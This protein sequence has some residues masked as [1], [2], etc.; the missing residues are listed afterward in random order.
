[1]LRERYRNLLEKTE[2][3]E[4]GKIYEIRVNAGATETLK[5]IKLEFLFLVVT[6]LDSKEIPI[7]IEILCLKKFLLIK[8]QIMFYFMILNILPILF[9]LS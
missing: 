8:N 6:S 2:L 9:F 4:P 3:I 5:D 1:M 7:L